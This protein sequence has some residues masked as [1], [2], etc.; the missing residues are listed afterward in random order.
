MTAQEFGR[1]QAL[2]FAAGAGLTVGIGAAGVNTASA[3]G[4]PPVPG[5]QGDRRANEM[6][7][8]LDDATL[9]HPSKEV[10]DA[11]TA[12]D[13]YLG[14][15]VE[16]GIVLTWLDMLKS[17]GYPEN[18]ASFLAPI[19]QPLEALSRIQLGVFDRFY[20]PGSEGFTTAFEYFGQ[21]VLFDPRANP[22]V[23]TMNATPAR[24]P[25]GYP[26]WHA[27]LRGMGLLGIHRRRWREIAP[28]VGLAWGLQKIANPDQYHVNPPLSRETVWRQRCYWLPRT[29]GQLDADFRDFPYPP[30]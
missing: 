10:T 6:W 5:M 14:G 26:T 11:F 25:L 2:R 7:F 9:Y 30:E 20:R 19:R 29:L 3:A 24:P 22:P 17:P 16:R 1:R 4:F 15:G 28:L 13:A 27:Y 21:G 18:Y 12:I 8:S 23:H